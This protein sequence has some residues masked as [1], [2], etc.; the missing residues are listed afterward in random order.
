MAYAQF[1]VTGKFDSESSAQKLLY[2]PLSQELTYRESQCYKVEYEGEED[3]LRAFVQKVLLDPISQNLQEGGQAVFPAAFILEYGM[4]TAALDLEKE[5]ILSYYRAL[6]EP[7]FQL[8]KLTLRKRIYVSGE[9]A[10]PAPFLRDVVNP[11]IHT[12]E[13]IHPGVEA[14]VAV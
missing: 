8:Q 12:S 14:A 4:K 1:E 11:A 5:T 3:A 13:V 6:E 7:G 2:A 9:G 10:D